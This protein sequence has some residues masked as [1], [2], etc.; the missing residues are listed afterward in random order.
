MGIPRLGHTLP[1][2][3]FLFIFGYTYLSARTQVLDG[4]NR[5]HGQ[6]TVAGYKRQGDSL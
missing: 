5:K 6:R 3:Y 4:H 2:G 1:F